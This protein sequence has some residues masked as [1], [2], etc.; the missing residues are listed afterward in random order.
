M[1]SNAAAELASAS[2]ATITAIA[3]IRYGMSISPFFRWM[4]N[5]ES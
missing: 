4:R 5:P 3:T 1:Q 2:D